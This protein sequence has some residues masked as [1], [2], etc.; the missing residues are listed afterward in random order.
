M[1]VLL[2]RNSCFFECVCVGGGG[3]EGAVVCGVGV[4]GEGIVFF[5]L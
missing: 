3:D 1:G 5:R 2:D 4:G